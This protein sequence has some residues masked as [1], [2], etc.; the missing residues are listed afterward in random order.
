MAEGF[1]IVQTKGPEGTGG[2]V[3]MLIGGKIFG[4]DNGFCFMGT[5]YADKATMKAK[6]TVQN[7]DS[8]V[9]SIFGLKGDYDL[10]VSTTIKGD[11]MTG[12]AMIAGDPTKSIGIQ[13]DKKSNL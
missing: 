3:A 9:P 2:C 12:T 7:F 6:V 13:L 1:W 4:G 11:S 5:Y 10:E 8:A